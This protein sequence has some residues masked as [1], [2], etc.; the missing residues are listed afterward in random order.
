MKPDDSSLTP[1]EYAKVKRE[2]ERMLAEADALGR[3]PTPISDILATAGVEVAPAEELD[4]SFL[5]WIR[6]KAGGTGATLKRALSKVLGLFDAKSRLIF[7][8]RTVLAVKQAFIKLHETG[9]A[10]LP[11][12]KDIYG[13]IEDCEKT[14]SPEISDLFDREA[15]VFASEVLFQ[16]DSFIQ[17]AS[18]HEFGILIPVRLSSKYGASIYAS[19]RQYVSKNLGACVVLIFDPPLPM[20][21]EGFAASLRRVV[22]SSLFREQVGNLVWPEIV[23]PGDEIGAMIPVGGRKMSG[24]REIQLTDRDGRR[25]ECIA[26]A[27]TQGHQVFVLIHLIKALTKSTIILPPLICGSSGID[28]IA[29]RY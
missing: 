7:V 22:S 16:V 12:Q 15:N 20:E 25:H 1:R 24:K 2:A 19:I 26:E 28:T 23:S 17:E 6:K 14:L 5:N 18:D 11:W 27:F 4:E 9:H 10:V 8:D 3:F 29:P 13:V 21:G